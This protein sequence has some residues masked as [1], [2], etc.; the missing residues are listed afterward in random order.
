MKGLILVLCVALAVNAEATATFPDPAEQLRNLATLL[1]EHHH[2][3]TR[4]VATP[5][6]TAPTP[7]NVTEEP[8]TGFN[9]LSCQI[10]SQIYFQSCFVAHGLHLGELLAE[11]RGSG[12]FG[13]Y[14]ILSEIYCKDHHC[15]NALLT[16][17]EVCIG[18]EVSGT[19][20]YPCM[21]GF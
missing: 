12:P 11:L 2:R 21:L 13:L 20:I 14:F 8:T 3:F 5:P 1:Q 9:Q 16:F 4:Q 7:T 19:K 15:Q 6:S 17:Y 18:T 10:A